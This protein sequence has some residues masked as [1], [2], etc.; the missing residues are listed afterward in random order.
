MSRVQHG[1]NAGFSPIH[2]ANTKLKFSPGILMNRN[3]LSRFEYE[4]SF[5]I[6]TPIETTTTVTISVRFL[7]YLNL[8]P[9][10]VTVSQALTPIP[11]N[12]SRSCLSVTVSQK[13]NR[14]LC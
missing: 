2:V 3:S 10:A 1:E 8:Y 5:A 6:F 7:Q 9:I 14:F 13:K 12:F 11:P 4:K